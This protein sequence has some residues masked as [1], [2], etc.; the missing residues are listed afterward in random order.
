MIAIKGC[1]PNPKEIVSALHQAGIE[2]DADIFE[3]L[4]RLPESFMER[5]REK[6]EFEEAFF[7]I[8]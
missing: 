8:G 1:P 3:N 6:P 4:E 7:K 2:A 5:Y